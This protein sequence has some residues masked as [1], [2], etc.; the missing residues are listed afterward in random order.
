MSHFQNLRKRLSGPDSSRCIAAAAVGI[1]PVATASWP[2]GRWSGVAARG[3]ARSAAPDG[4]PRMDRARLLLRLPA[5]RAHSAMGLQRV[6]K[7]GGLEAATK[8]AVGYVYL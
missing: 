8:E 5:K 7:S 2:A 6:L 4:Q 1:K 3:L